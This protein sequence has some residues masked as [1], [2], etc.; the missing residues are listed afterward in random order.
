MNIKILQWNIWY[1]ENLKKNVEFIKKADPDIFCAQE[2]RQIDGGNIDIPSEIHEL[3]DHKY[4]YY[5]QVSATWDNRDD[6]TTQGNG[7]YSKFPILD[8]R[9]VYVTRFKHNPDSAMDEGRVYM[10]ADLSIQNKTLTISTIHLSYSNGLVMNE[11]RKKEADI[12]VNT[13][14]T[15]KNNFVFTADL[16]AS[17]DS[18]V[19]KK[20]LKEGN[21]KNAGPDFDQKTW[22][23][24]PFNYHG[25]E[26]P[27]F[28]WRPD[29]VFV[30]RDLNVVSS[31]IIKTDVS[32]HYPILTVIDF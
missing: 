3:L 20:I 21:I 11:N 8:R 26:E 25:Y 19:V 5:Y 12:L 10:E 31:E 2:L 9:H 16:N 24:K 15:K 30:T 22:P 13:L 4:E 14:K 17:P 23:T 7:I 1:K 27:L 29:Y 28:H 6:V 18:Y 32:D